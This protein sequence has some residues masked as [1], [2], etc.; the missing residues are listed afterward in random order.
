MHFSLFVK[1]NVPVLKYRKWVQVMIILILYMYILYNTACVYIVQD[2]S[3]HLKK[4]T[5][6]K[7]HSSWPYKLSI[8]KFIF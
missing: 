1:N 6:V 2:A 4:Y 3:M 8:I 7:H 5:G